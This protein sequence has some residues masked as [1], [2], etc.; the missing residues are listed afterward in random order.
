LSLMNPIPVM[1]PGV[2][3]GSS[4]FICVLPKEKTVK[5]ED[6]EFMHS[7]SVYRQQSTQRI[8][9]DSPNYSTNRR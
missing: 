1:H 9:T 8:I 5:R 7:G 4:G 2:F 3:N 6:G